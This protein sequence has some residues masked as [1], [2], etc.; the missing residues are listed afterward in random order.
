M[1]LLEI[2]FVITIVGIF[3]FAIDDLFIDAVSFWCGARPK[4]IDLSHL[5]VESE[6]SEKKIAIMIANW[7]EHDVLERMIKGNLRRIDYGEYFFFLGVY[8]NDKATLA[9]A[10]QLSLVYFP[11][12][13]VVI[14]EFEGPTSKGQMLNQIARAILDREKNLGRKFDLFVMHD[15]EDILHPNSLQLANVASRKYDFI[16]IPVFS[17][18]LPQNE[19]VGATYLDEFAE[20]HT[21]DIMVRQSLRSAIPSAGTGTTMTRHLLLAL[22]AHRQN[23]FLREDTL[24]EDYDLGLTAHKLGFRTDFEC[25]YF[26]EDGKRHW[27]ATREYFPKSFR[28]SLRQKTRWVT[29]IV[30]QGAENHHWKGSLV[31]IYF[32][33]RHRRSFINMFLLSFSVVLSFWC[34]LDWLFET[35]QFQSLVQLPALQILFIGNTVSLVWRVFVRMWAVSRVHSWRQALL[36]PLRWWVANIINVSATFWAWRE[37]SRAKR[38]GVHPQ[39][40]KTQHELPADFGLEVS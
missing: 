24:T 10:Q 8:P 28:T 14:N 19:W 3:L 20:A 31:D 9:I 5:Q 2:V 17:F 32:Y 15:S 33:W 11:Q 29:G 12:V 30:F 13:Q 37:Y 35:S 40:K 38:L 18:N 4:Q 23:R 39:W 25:C 1:L 22:L 21:K 27:I 6:E 7:K 26:I 36:V 16:Q 34:G